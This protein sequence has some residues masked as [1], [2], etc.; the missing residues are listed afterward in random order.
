MNLIKAIQRSVPLPGYPTSKCHHSM[1]G[2]WRN[3]QETLFRCRK[4]LPKASQGWCPK[5][6]AAQ[7]QDDQAR[8]KCRNRVRVGSCWVGGCREV[9]EAVLGW[10]VKT[11]ESMQAANASLG[12]NIQSDDDLRRSR[13]AEYW[14]KFDHPVGWWKVCPNTPSQKCMS[15]RAQFA[16]QKGDSASL[17]FSRRL[18]ILS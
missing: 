16:C 18:L 7:L 9:D 11:K 5:K 12:R 14:Y 3:R 1:S 8:I 13:Y 2:L 17:R 6:Q 4:L 15:I 10:V